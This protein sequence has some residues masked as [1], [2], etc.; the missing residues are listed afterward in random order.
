MSDDAP[1]SPEELFD[2]FPEGLAIFRRVQ[3]A[4]SAIGEASVAVTRSQVT[5][6]RRKAFAF[7]WRPGQYVSSGVPAVLSIA[8]PYEVTS[9]RFKEIAHPAPTVWMHHL[10]L[11]GVSEVDDQVRGWLVNAYE[12]AR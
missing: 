9:D 6:R 11:R 1:R 3:Q 12:N 5:F 2:G 8:M 10:E 7:V 4:V